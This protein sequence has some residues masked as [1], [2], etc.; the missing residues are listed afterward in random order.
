MTNKVPKKGNR[1]WRCCVCVEK[2]FVIE[3]NS[4]IIFLV[5][6]VWLIGAFY[7]YFYWILLSAMNT[8]ILIKYN[9]FSKY[10]AKIFIDHEKE[11]LYHRR[12]HVYYKLL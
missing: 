12:E 4:R 7:K 3:N 10:S 2:Y 1:C 11:I 6:T 8:Y 5:T 9:K